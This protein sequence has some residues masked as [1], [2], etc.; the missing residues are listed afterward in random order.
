MNLVVSCEHATARVP[1]RYAAL[2]ASADARA[3]LA[4][5]RGFDDGARALARD[6]SRALDAPLVAARATRLL[7]DPNRSRTNRVVFSEITRGLPRE[8]RERLLERWWA[9]HRDAV[10]AAVNEAARGAV[11]HLSVHSFTPVWDGAERAVD[12]GLLYDPSRRRERA[13][14]DALHAALAAREPG[15]RVRRN[16]PY[17]GTADGL[18]TALRRAFREARYLGVELEVNQRLVADAGAWRA[19][20]RAIVGAVADAISAAT[21]G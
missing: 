21:A 17:R 3:A 7:V 18:T 5:H 9:P 4:S 15:W 20:R 19:A 2:F 11:L 1:E 12:L 8:E 10:A 16:Q 6:L 14:C 13:F